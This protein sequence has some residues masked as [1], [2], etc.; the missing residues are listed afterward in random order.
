METG[1]SRMAQVDFSKLAA[2]DEMKGDSREDT[3]L[4]RGM[5]ADAQ[6]YLERQRWCAR[7]TER[8]FGLGVGG[9]IA[10]FLFRIVPSGPA[11]D[12]LVWVIVGDVPS[13]YVSTDEAPNAAAALDGYLGAMEAWVKAVK[14]GEPV[15]DLAPVGVEPTLEM[16]AMLES[17]VNFI[18]KQV[19]A[20]Y[21]ADL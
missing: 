12:D 5:L 20:R 3:R 11:A 1:S 15:D 7:I 21:S 14:H 4:L 10:V 8:Y 9:I 17:R 2:V 6:S 18:D 13:L 19:L 16:A